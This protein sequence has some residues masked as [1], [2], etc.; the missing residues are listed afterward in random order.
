[1]SQTG[2]EKLPHLAGLTLADH[3]DGKA[4]IYILVGADQYWYLVTGGL[5]RGDSGPTAM[6]AKLG[7]V[8]SGPVNYLMS[9]M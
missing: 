9:S 4:D 7:W 3:C 2:S 5:I 6:H 1:V 8:L